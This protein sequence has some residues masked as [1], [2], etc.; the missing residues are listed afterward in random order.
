MVVHL[1]AVKWMPKKT[2]SAKQLTVHFWFNFIIIFSQK[3]QNKKSQNDWA[4][5]AAL[6]LMLAL[7][8]VIKKCEKVKKW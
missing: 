4:S 1:M 3:K 8:G 5:V 6:A 7:D 2:G